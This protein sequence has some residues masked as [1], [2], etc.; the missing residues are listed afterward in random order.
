MSHS[1]KRS[2]QEEELRVPSGNSHRYAHPLITGRRY[3][4]DDVD[5][6]SFRGT[7][8]RIKHIRCRQLYVF[9]NAAGKEIEILPADIVHYRLESGDG[10]FEL[11]D[12]TGDPDWS[13][14]GQIAPAAEMADGHLLRF[15]IWASGRQHRHSHR[16]GRSRQKRN[17]RR[18]L[19]KKSYL[20]ANG[21][22]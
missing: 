22:K 1:Q 16:G 13:A 6:D 8:A 10:L 5:G 11:P 17:T 4:I 9:V 14:N 12:L 7:F 19:N 21:T 2:R 3:H 15:W 18:N 20:K